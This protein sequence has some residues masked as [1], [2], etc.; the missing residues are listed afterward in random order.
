MEDELI[1]NEEL[2]E[3]EGVHHEDIVLNDDET[4]HSPA[5]IQPK[6]L[7]IYLCSTNFV[8]RF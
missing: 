3:E 8:Q 2:P 4:P 1:I 5:E 6:R 7:V